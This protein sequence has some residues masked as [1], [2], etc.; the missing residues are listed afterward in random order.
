MKQIVICLMLVL[1]SVSL[2]AE[3]KELTGVLSSSKVEMDGKKV[4]AYVIK[5]ADGEFKI[6]PKLSGKLKKFEGK[7]VTIK[8]DV[9][10][11]MMIE[12]IS[13]LK[14]EKKKK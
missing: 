2:S 3:T 14:P 8:A 5:T 12:K 7:S 10:D 4:T 9:N 1:G 13:S 6:D 11:E